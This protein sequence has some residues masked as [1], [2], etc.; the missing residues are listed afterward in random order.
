M[1]LFQRIIIVIHGPMKTKQTTNMQVIMQMILTHI[2]HAIIACL[3]R[4]Q[5][6]FIGEKQARF[7]STHNW[8]ILVTTSLLI[9]D[10]PEHQHKIWKKQHL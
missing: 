4:S 2:E 6:Q 8:I 10:P 9:I 7:F 1:S 5:G 3:D